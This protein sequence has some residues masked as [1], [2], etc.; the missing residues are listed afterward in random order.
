MKKLKIICIIFFGRAISTGSTLLARSSRLVMFRWEISC[1][2]RQPPPCTF[3]ITDASQGTTRVD[4]LMADISEALE[5]R[6]IKMREGL[7]PSVSTTPLVLFFLILVFFLPFSTNIHN[8][9]G[10]QRLPTVSHPAKFI[11][12]FL[13]IFWRL[14]VYQINR[15]AEEALLTFLPWHVCVISTRSPRCKVSPWGTT[16]PSNWLIAVETKQKEKQY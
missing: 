5:G 14:S 3:V 4:I 11:Q 13:F 6:K 2:I 8:S 15:Q 1:Q 16:P 12:I 10:T 9:C 7:S